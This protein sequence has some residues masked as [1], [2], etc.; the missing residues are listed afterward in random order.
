MDVKTQQ[1]GLHT[2]SSPTKQHTPIFPPAKLHPQRT[3]PDKT[4]CKP[5]STYTAV[6]PRRPHNGV[7]C[8]CV[9]RTAYSARVALPCI[10][11]AD[12]LAVFF[13]SRWHWPSTFDHDIQTLATFCTMHLT[14]KFCHPTF[15]CLEVIM[16]TNAQTKKL[17]NRCHWKHPL[18][19][20]TLCHATPVGNYY[21]TLNAVILEINQWLNYW[22][23]E[24]NKRYHTIQR[25]THNVFYKADM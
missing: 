3:A 13:C 8:C 12:D 4:A 2:M 23:D 6:T 19:F 9:Q 7:F 24:E 16:R 1:T 22:K 21:S 18:H 11:N 15:N 17:T 20:A 14:A 10:V 5:P 25:Y